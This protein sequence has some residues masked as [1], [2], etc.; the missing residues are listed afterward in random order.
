MSNIRANKIDY[1][2]HLS[3]FFTPSAVER[4]IALDRTTIDPHGSLRNGSLS[5]G[6]GSG[7]FG[8]SIF[9]VT[10]SS[11]TRTERTREPDGRRYRCLC[12][13]ASR[14]SHR[15]YASEYRSESVRTSRLRPESRPA[16]GASSHYP[17]DTTCCGY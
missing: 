5:N 1:I 15:R 6:F 7:G 4:A 11:G 10:G 14:I 2:R 13:A 16:P 3:T 8:L 9:I 17:D 12:C